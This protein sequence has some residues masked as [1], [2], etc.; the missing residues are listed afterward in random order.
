MKKILFNDRYAL[1]KSVLYGT[2]ISTRRIIKAPRKRNG[3]VIG[4]FQ[5]DR[6]QNWWDVV[7]VDED[8][9]E[10]EKNPQ[11]MP[12]YHMRETV[13]IAQSYKTIYDDMDDN[14]KKEIYRNLLGKMPGWNNKMFVKASLMPHHITITGIYPERLQDITEEDCEKEG[15]VVDYIIRNE[16]RVKQALF[17]DTKTRK[18]IS[19]DTS[20]EAFHGLI[21]RLDKNM[22]NDNP[23][24]W[25]YMFK[26]KD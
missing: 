24:V 10:L 21:D 3:V 26:L 20:K 15:I 19:F 25:V 23:F 5:V 7:L 11:L 8:G 14:G 16:T 13:A 1:T 4:D 22:W 9:Y 6:G 2:K 18:I 17:P 12:L